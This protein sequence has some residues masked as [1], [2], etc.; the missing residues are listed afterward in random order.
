MMTQPIGAA[1]ASEVGPI[2][3]E[4][5]AV[6]RGNRGGLGHSALPAAPPAGASEDSSGSDPSDRGG[7]GGEAFVRP[8]PCPRLC[9]RRRHRS[10]P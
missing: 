7:G 8:R 6:G 10:G 2:P 9:E 3:R 1:P 4:R 5:P